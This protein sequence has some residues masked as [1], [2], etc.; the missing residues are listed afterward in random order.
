MGDWLALRDTT[1]GLGG[2]R[3][4]ASIAIAGVGLGMLRVAWGCVLRGP[5]ERLRIDRRLTQGVDRVRIVDPARDLWRDLMRGGCFASNLG[6][7]IAGGLA[8]RWGMGLGDLALLTASGGFGDCGGF[9]TACGFDTL[10]CCGTGGFFGLVESAAHGW[11]GILGLMGSGCLGC[12]TRGRVGGGCGGF[13]L[14]FGEEGLLADLLGGAVPELRAILTSGGGEIAILC[15][16]KIGPGVKDRDVLRSLGRR[17]IIDPVHLSWIHYSV[18][19]VQ[20]AM[21]VFFIVPVVCQLKTR[22]LQLF[23]Q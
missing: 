12:V 9:G 4:F 20:T 23:L 16:M 7:G 6:V 14:R 13:C 10:G 19:E 5:Q 22:V 17:R 21:L 3:I 15:T 8:L 1:L 11:V 18:P 2:W